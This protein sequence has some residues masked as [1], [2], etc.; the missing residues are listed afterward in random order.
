MPDGVIVVVGLAVVVEVSVFIVD[1]VS[2]FRELELSEVLYE[3]DKPADTLIEY[4]GDC[5][6]VL[7][8]D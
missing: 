8:D 6:F 1:T 3:L 4:V 7:D 5:V 2:V